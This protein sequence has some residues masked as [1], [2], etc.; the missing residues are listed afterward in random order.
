MD[1]SGSISRSSL[2]KTEP[3][4]SYESFV[5]DLDIGD[6]FT[7]S[8]IDILVKVSAFVSNSQRRAKSQLV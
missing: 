5:N 7:T 4:I 1:R 3:T 6:S 8:L 2:E